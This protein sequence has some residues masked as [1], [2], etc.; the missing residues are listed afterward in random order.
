MVDKNMIICYDVL[1]IRS[2][3]RKEVKIVLWYWVCRAWADS[4]KEK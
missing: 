3:M 4:K 2:N 1:S